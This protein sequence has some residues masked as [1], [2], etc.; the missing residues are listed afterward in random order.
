MS[1]VYDVEPVMNTPSVNVDVRFDAA[2]ARRVSPALLPPATDAPLY[3]AVGGKE[4]AGFHE[5]NS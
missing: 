5:Q 1:G 4:Q 2:Q 3:T